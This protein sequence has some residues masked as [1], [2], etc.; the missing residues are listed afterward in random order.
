ME[1]SMEV[2][3]RKFPLKFVKTHYRRDTTEA[4]KKIY[5]ANEPLSLKH[6]KTEIKFFKLYFILNI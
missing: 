1:I 5:I 2:L 4:N 6:Y 3:I